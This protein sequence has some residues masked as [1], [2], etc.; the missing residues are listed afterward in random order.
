MKLFG[1]FSV[2]DR[3]EMVSHDCHGIPNLKLG[4]IG[5]IAQI[6]SDSFADIVWNQNQTRHTFCQY[7]PQML[8][9]TLKYVDKVD[10]IK[11]N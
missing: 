8:R 10:T 6:H 7:T 11:P 9:L 2:G 1:I 4:D 3:V 5:K